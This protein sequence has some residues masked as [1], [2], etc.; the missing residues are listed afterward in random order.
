MLKRGFLLF[1]KKIKEENI[2]DDDEDFQATLAQSSSKP[3]KD[4]KLNGQ[5]EPSLDNKGK[6]SRGKEKDAPIIKDE[7]TSPKQIKHEKPVTKK[8]SKTESLTKMEI[9]P[10]TEKPAPKVIEVKEEKPTTTTTK[11]PRT[12]SANYASYLHREGPKALG[13]KEIPEGEEDCLAGLTFI[14]TGVLESLE[15]DDAKALIEKYGGKVMTTLSKNTKYIV[16]GRD[17][18][19]S[20]LDKAEKLGTKQLDEDGLLD[21]IRTLPGKGPPKK[22]K[23][24]KKE[25]ESDKLDSSISEK[26]KKG[27]DLEDEFEMDIDDSFLLDAAP[28]I[29]E[30]KVEKKI[31]SSPEK[32]PIVRIKEEP[33]SDVPKSM[34]V[35]KYKPTSLK[36]VI[37]QQGDKSNAKKLLNWVVNWSRNRRLNKK[38]IPG[39]FN[40]SDDGSGF[41]AA[42]LSGPPG[43]GKTT[44]ALLVCKEAS[45]DYFELNASDTRSKKNLQQMVSQL[46]GNQTLAGCFKENAEKVSSKH[47]IIMD[48][49]DGM[50]GNEDRGGMAEL[51]SFIKASKVPIICI[52]NDRNHPKIRSLSNHCFD[53]R[54]QRPRVEQIKAA[55]M[56]IALKK[57]FSRFC[58]SLFFKMLLLLQIKI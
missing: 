11:K 51:I 56:S 12:G 43:V 36:Q 42:L 2:H 14:I 38:P 46:L 17:A 50:S 45:F 34:W 20:K 7:K 31:D 48:E 57:K 4:K 5:K 13:S 22:A 39:R 37:G 49:V 1:K 24:I 55:M 41:K 16:I 15:R 53:L 32:R 26:S 23:P 47:V 9:T 10:K 33:N 6:D 19:A 21:L 25:I 3:V 30:E 29:K 44:T 54:F 58:S 8:K 28:D 35:D 40:P 52:C 27:I 18:G